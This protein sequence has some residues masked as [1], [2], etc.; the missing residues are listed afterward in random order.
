M[1]EDRSGF[2]SAARGALSILALC[3]LGAVAAGAAEPQ[4]DLVRI[5]MARSLAGPALWG[6]EPFAAKYGLHTEVI[7][8]TTN[9]EMQHYLQ[10]GVEV[11]SLGYQSPAVMAEQKVG[12]VKIIGELA[13]SGQN[14]IMRKGVALNSWK[15]LEGKRIG[16]PPGTYVSILFTLAA[17][18]NHVD[19]AKVKLV[20]TT[21]AGTAELQALKGGDLDGL[22]LWSPII[23]RAVVED[24]AYYPTCC[25]IGTTSEFGAGNQILGANTEFLKDHAKV[26]RFLKAFVEAQEFYS[27]NRDKAAALIE[28]YTGVSEAVIT[29]ALKHETWDPRVEIKTAVNVAKEGPRFGFTKTDM[30]GDV[31]A[32][33]DLSYLAEATGRPA[34]QLGSLGH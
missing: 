32:F 34:A 15:D 9:A 18:A 29:E 1:K 22:L 6:L 27:K 3:A 25:D 11:G 5:T 7:D 21:A 30:S 31:P 26:V 17:E 28:K 10:S 12:N 4:P 33:F 20:N 16:G 24:Y 8:T 2:A 19:L 13:I 23:D 14:L